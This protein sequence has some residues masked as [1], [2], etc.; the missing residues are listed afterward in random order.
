MS[1]NEKTASVKT[2][3]AIVVVIAFISGALIGAAGDRIYLVVTHQIFPRNM[4]G[5]M[6]HRIAARLSREL[7]LTAQQRASVEAILDRR[8]HRIESIWSSVRPQVRA[9]IDQTNAEIAQLL[10][11]EQ[12]VKF[13]A[14]KMKLQQRRSGR[15]ESAGGR[16][17][18]AE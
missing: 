16:P 9:E 14:L 11:P 7:D 6:S 12:R 8:A 4:S 18:P 17:P 13:E 3:A 1:A 5:P 10:T 15:H 2:V